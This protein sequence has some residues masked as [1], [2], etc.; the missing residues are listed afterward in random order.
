[1]QSLSV[2]IVPSEATRGGGGD[3]TEQQAFHLQL[4]SAKG[5]NRW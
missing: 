3:G 1:M 2:P 5:K 4:F